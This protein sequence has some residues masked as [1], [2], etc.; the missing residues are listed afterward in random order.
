MVVEQLI[1]FIET[2][3]DIPSLS[4]TPIRWELAF[5]RGNTEMQESILRIYAVAVIISVLLVAVE[6]NA[7]LFAPSI[8]FRFGLRIKTIHGLR[9]NLETFDI[10]KEYKTAHVKFVRFSK[11][12]CLF[13]RRFGFFSNVHVAIKGEILQT[14]SGTIMIWRIPLGSTMFYS[15]WLLGW[16]SPFFR[17]FQLTANQIFT[18]NFV[19][20]VS[21]LLLVA[22]IFLF[23]YFYSLRSEQKKAKLALYLLTPYRGDE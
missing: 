20:S 17:I 21:L 18:A 22:V 11:N 9:I 2:C 19:F 1:K 6:T 7:M 14:E 16:V 5:S 10:G 15:L 8:L 13:S 23:I 3:R 4:V 12:S